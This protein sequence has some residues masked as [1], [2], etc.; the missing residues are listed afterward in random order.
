MKKLL[1]ISMLIFSC[2]GQTKADMEPGFEPQFRYL[3]EQQQSRLNALAQIPKNQRTASQDREYRQL[4]AQ[5]KDN[6]DWN[7]RL[8]AM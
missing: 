7:M 6:R 1:F 3:T 2:I 5:D 4:F 8:M